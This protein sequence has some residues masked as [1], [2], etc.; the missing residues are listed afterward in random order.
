MKHIHLDFSKHTHAPKMIHGVNNGPICKQGIID[1]SRHYR[2]IGVPSVRLHDTDGAN[3]RFYVD[4][5][6]IFP[7]FDADEQDA[8]NYYF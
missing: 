2:E 7:N 4:V 8:S 3:S 6:R 1:L 5:S